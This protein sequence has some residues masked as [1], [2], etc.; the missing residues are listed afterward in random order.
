M[1]ADTSSNTPIALFN[2][3]FIFPSLIKKRNPLMGAALAL[4]KRLGSFEDDEMPADRP[5][6]GLL[7]V[8]YG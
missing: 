8:A 3:F 6:S 1:P 7:L 2:T 5:A 4:I